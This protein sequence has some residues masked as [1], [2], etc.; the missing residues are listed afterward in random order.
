[1]QG[2]SLK[3]PLFRHSMPPPCSRQT[4]GPALPPTLQAD[5]LP[6]SR[7]AVN[8][9]YCGSSTYKSTC[10]SSKCGRGNCKRRQTEGY[11]LL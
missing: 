9:N 3:A 10:N 4:T 5:Y 1:M 7:A 11:H 6:D 8:L 2:D